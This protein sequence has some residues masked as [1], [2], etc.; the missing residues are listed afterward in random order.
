MPQEEINALK[1]CFVKALDPLRVYL[2]GSY[3]YGIPDQ[4]SDFDFYIVVDDSK[5]D[6]LDLTLRA[7][8]A[9]SEIKRHPVDIL[10]GTKSRF[11]NRKQR[12]SIENEVYHKGVLLYDA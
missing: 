3:A 1:N 12:P 6:T 7:Y 4:D 8:S 5:T 9:C 11:E 2:F 10:V